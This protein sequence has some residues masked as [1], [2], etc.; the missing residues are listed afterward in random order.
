MSEEKKADRQARPER[1]KEGARLFL[2]STGTKP[3][4]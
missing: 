3:R 2:E 1:G 4:A